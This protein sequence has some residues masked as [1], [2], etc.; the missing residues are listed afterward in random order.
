MDL[1]LIKYISN[2]LVFLCWLCVVVLLESGGKCVGG[3]SGKNKG[4]G[5]QV[6]KAYLIQPKNRVD[7]CGGLVYQWIVHIV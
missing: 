7:H 1:D 5:A 4:W 6:H 2:K 3:G